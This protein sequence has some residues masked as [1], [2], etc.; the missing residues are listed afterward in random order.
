VIE[1]N[2]AP[3]AEARR[4][5]ARGRSS[6]SLPTLPSLGADSRT[7][8]MGAG[9]LLLALLLGFGIWR[10]GQQRAELEERV[11]TEV[12]CAPA[13]TRSSRRSA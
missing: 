9:G 6:L 12:T 11:E 4:P 8:V 5:S 7:V 1:I 13:R 3:G 2:L 10:M